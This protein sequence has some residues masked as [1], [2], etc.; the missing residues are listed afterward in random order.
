MAL[1]ALLL[2]IAAL[3][4]VALVIADVISNPRARALTP[5]FVTALLI[6]AWVAQTVI[7]SG[8]RWTIR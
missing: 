4:V 5:W 1:I 2:V 7:L 6:A 3:I 8:W